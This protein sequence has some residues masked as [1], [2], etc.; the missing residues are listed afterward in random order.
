MSHPI[1]ASSH[2]QSRKFVTGP[3]V[4]CKGG[5]RGKGGFLGT[6]T[7]RMQ[8]TRFF[9]SSSPSPPPPLNQQATPL[10]QIQRQ[11]PQP[12]ARRPKLPFKKPVIASTSALSQFE[13]P[14]TTKDFTNLVNSTMKAID[15]KLAVMK[16]KK[17][18]GI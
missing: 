14:K 13:A 2:Q 15:D 7:K 17:D 1:A 9:P 16:S 8:G 12:S 6:Q 3:S 10:A 11:A 4:I 5:F 18:G